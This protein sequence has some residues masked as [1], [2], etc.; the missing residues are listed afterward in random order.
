MICK[1]PQPLAGFAGSAASAATAA[2]PSATRLTD[3]KRLAVIEYL[4]VL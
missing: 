1:R 4:K 2:I 3:D